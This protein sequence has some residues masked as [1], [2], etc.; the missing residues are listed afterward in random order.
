MQIFIA[1]NGRPERY[2][3]RHLHTKVRPPG[4]CPRCDRDGGLKA[5]GYYFRHTTGTRGQAIRVGI[6]RFKCR[7][8]ATTIS[9]L[10]NFVQPYHFVSNLTI[11]RSFSGETGSADVQRNRDL[12]RRYWNRFKG[13]SRRLCLIIGGHAVDRRNP[14]HAAR[15]LWRRL[16]VVWQDLATCTL[17]LVH[18]F[19]ATCFGQY[20]C[21]QR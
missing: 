15:V 14:A 19:Q 21:H 1:V 3:E 2:V 16:S 13:W 9:C 12:L 20:L 18:D 7:R 4:R 8:C 10:P 11:Q 17:R 5:H 6:R